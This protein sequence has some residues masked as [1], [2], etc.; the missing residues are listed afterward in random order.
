MSRWQRDGTSRCRRCRS[1]R[2]AEPTRVGCPFQHDDTGGP[3]AQVDRAPVGTDRCLAADG[4]GRAAS[5]GAAGAQAVDQ[6]GRPRRHLVRACVARTGEHEATSVAGQRDR[7]N[8][9]EVLVAL[10]AP[11]PAQAA[12]GTAAQLVEVTGDRPHPDGVAVMR[13]RQTAEARVERGG[14]DG[15]PRRSRHLRGQAA[16]IGERPAGRSAVERRHLSGAEHV[17]AQ[18]VTGDDD[19]V[20]AVQRR[21]VRHGR[22]TG[23]GADAAGHRERGVDGSRLNTP[24]SPAPPTT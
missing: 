13:D 12:R 14:D 23:A 19:V 2:I 16:A 1:S 20:G 7:R 3:V 8:P 24:M 6:R 17:D 9:T 15:A 10:I 21:R 5:I 4:A 22:T 11:H 18:A